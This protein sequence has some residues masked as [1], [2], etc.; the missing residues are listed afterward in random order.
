MKKNVTPPPTQLTVED[1]LALLKDSIDLRF[2]KKESNEFAPISQYNPTLQLEFGKQ[3]N[4]LSQ[5]KALLAHSTQNIEHLLEQIKTKR[6]IRYISCVVIW[7]S[8]FTPFLN[9]GGA[10]ETVFGFNLIS[11]IVEFIKQPAATLN[12]GIFVAIYP[13]MLLIYAAML[14]FLPMRLNLDKTRMRLWS[15][16]ASS[17]ILFFFAALILFAAESD[18]ND[19][20]STIGFGY[21]L[22]MAAIFAYHFLT[23]WADRTVDEL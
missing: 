7:I 20:I 11:T 12:W 18:I 16:T 17:G 10:N 15:V 6:H 9:M 23:Q 2:V 3:S 14:A 13:T 22:S 1:Q 21:Y 4:A 19:A 8:L 5:N